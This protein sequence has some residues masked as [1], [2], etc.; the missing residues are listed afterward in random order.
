MITTDGDHPDDSNPPTPIPTE[1]KQK[2]VPTECKVCG[3]PAVYSYVG[4][5]ACASCKMFFKRNATTKQV[6]LPSRLDF[7]LRHSEF[8]GF[9][10]ERIRMSIQWSM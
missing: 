3:G 9:F 1:T 2:R 4:V 8:L 5:I 6:T 10:S 7:D